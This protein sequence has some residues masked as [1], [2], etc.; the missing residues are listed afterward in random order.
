MIPKFIMFPPLILL[1]LA[2]IAVIALI[3][4]KLCSTRSWIALI[5]AFLLLLILLPILVLIPAWRI[6]SRHSI[7]ALT[8]SSTQNED[9]TAIWLPGIEDEFEA[10]VY[11]SKLS[12]VRS[13]GLRIGEPVRQVHG[14][15][16]PPSGIILFKGAH[17]VGLLEEFTKA[18]I[19]HVFPETKWTIAPE[20]VAVQTDQVGIRLD[21][22]KVQAHPVPWPGKF[23]REMTSGTIQASVLA[24][25]KQASIKADFVDKPWV[26]DFSDFLNTKPNSRFI[27]AKSSD[28]CITEAEANRQALENAC[29]KITKMLGQASRKLSGI[30]APFARPVNSADILEEDFILD[31]FAQSFEGTAGRIWRQALLIDASTDK[32]TQLAHQKAVMARARKMSWARM[33]LSVVGLLVLIT[34]VYA[35]LNAAT[36]GYYVWSLRVA[37]IVLALIAIILLVV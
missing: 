8:P 25:D 35:F 30:P 14:D 12:A 34:V 7:E 33:F 36:K 6:D 1:L 17:D 20:T 37:G 31:R 10:N 28:S 22:V 32:L 5:L 24:T 11:P 26:E 9:T 15:Q 13:L 4:I 19:A 3:T 16:K 23:E 29:T 21:F 18:A 2:V 27:I